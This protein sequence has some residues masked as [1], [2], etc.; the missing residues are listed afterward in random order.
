[1][2]DTLTSTDPAIEM[3]P[4]AAKSRRR[5]Q[6]V[7]RALDIL[8]VFT[9]AK[10]EMKLGEVAAAAGLN[11]STCHHLL[12]TLLERGYV[13]QSPRGRTYYLGGRIIELAASRVR[14]MDL[15]EIATPELKRLNAETGETV[16]LAVMLG[17]DLVTLAKIDS[18]HAVRV[19]S[20]SIGKS[21]AAHATATGK[22]I[23]AWLPE[24]EIARIVAEKGLTRFTPRTIVELPELIEHLRL[25]RR[26]GYAVDEEEFQPGVICIGSAIRDHSGAVIGSI[27]CSLPV[28]RAQP[29]HLESVKD[30]VRASARLLSERMGE[31]QAPP[32]E[33]GKAGTE[34]AKVSV[35]GNSNANRRRKQPHGHA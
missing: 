33:P 23:L 24:P 26:N 5:I 31:V 28:M 22:A 27:C 3:P 25:V 29:E 6:S 20:G 9:R 14:Q 16:H 18:P 17:H 10:G 7:D 32:A 13:G 1:M 8:E 4:P 30:K 11:V 15:V 35:N 21:N 2:V 34:A 19:D 12:T